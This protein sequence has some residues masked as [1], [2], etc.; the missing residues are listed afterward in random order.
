MIGYSLCNETINQSIP[1]PRVRHEF[2]LEHPQLGA[3]ARPPLQGGYLL[4]KLSE[5]RHLAAVHALLEV[6]HDI[7]R[8]GLPIVPR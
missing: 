1:L 2:R 6:P 3:A 8:R 7:G 5:E 4:E